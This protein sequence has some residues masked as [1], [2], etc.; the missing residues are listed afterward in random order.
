MLEQI[1]NWQTMT[2]AEIVAYAAAH[3]ETARPMNAQE[4]RN[5]LADNRLAWFGVGG[6]WR[7]PLAES[8]ATLDGSGDAAA[9]ELAAGIERLLSHLASPGSVQVDTHLPNHGPLLAGIVGALGLSGDIVAGLYALGGGRKFPAW[10]IDQVQAAID[11]EE[12]KQ[13]AA[14]QPADETRHEVLLSCN[15]GTD[16]VMR[17]M[18]RVTPVEYANGVELR[19]GEARTVVNDAALVAALAPIIEGLIDG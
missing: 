1:P 12:A 7:G 10:S 4:L 17:V 19:R 14:E 9:A 2:A 5:Y 6:G 3:H 8:V 13:A 18:A 15:R 11:A 16:G